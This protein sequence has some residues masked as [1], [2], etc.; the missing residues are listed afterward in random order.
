MALDNANFIAELSI[1]DPPGSDPLSQGDDQIRTIKR[2]TFQSFPNIDKAI[3]FDSDTLNLAAIKNQ[4]NIFTATQQIND[5]ALHMN[6][7]ADV[8][9]R[10]HFQRASVDLWRLQM[11]AD[12]STNNF[13][14]LRFS[15]IGAFIDSPWAVDFASGVVDFAHV[16]TVLGAPLWIAGE[17]RTFVNTVTPGTNWFIADGTNGTT[18]LADRWLVGA[19]AFSAPAGT[20]INA[21]LD[22]VTT[23]TGVT[24]STVLTEAQLAAHNHTVWMTNNPAGGITDV[25]L[26]ATDNVFGGRRNDSSKQFAKSNGTRDVIG[27][28]GSGSGHNHTDGGNALVLGEPTFTNTVQPVSM[29][30]A[31]YQYVP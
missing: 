30:V 5:N 1:T 4:A 13:G 2:A 28:A 6:A 22:T 20:G 15:A 8:T 19:G 23:A 11:E 25:Q 17:V 7:A 24:G 27:N 12:A 3:V 18:N 14:L 21:K 29:A 26:N 10:I 9:M 16:P 31:F